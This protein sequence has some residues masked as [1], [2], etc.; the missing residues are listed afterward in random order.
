MNEVLTNIIQG[1]SADWI[2]ALV[3]GLLIATIPDSSGRNPTVTVKY[4]H[5]QRSDKK[6]KNNRLYYNF[7]CNGNY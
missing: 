4:A 1:D 6:A 7:N 3:Q 2:N 5:N